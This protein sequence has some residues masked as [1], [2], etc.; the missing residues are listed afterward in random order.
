MHAAAEAAI[1]RGDDTVGP[2]GLCKPADA[3]SHKLGVLDQVGRMGDHAGQDFLARRQLHLFPDLPFVFVAGIGGLERIILGIPRA[4]L[5]CAIA[6]IQAPSAATPAG[7]RPALKLAMSRW[8]SSWP[9]YLIG[10]L[11]TGL[12]LVMNCS[13]RPQPDCGSI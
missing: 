11:T 2:H 13:G 7:L 9:L 3:V 6:F 5:D 1:G 10:P 4:H 12:W 8:I